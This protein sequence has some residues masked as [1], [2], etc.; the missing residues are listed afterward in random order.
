MVAA[1]LMRGESHNCLGNFSMAARDV[2]HALAILPPLLP[3]GLPHPDHV[4]ARYRLVQI[5]KELGELDKTLQVLRFCAAATRLLMHE[6][7][8]QPDDPEDF[9]DPTAQTWWWISFMSQSESSN[10]IMG[11]RQRALCSE[12]PKKT[13]CPRNWALGHMPRIDTSASI[14]K[15]RASKPNC[16]YAQS[17]EMSGSVTKNV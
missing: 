17:A 8:C 7:V 1:L 2:E 4:V 5:W 3:G 14:A 13:P 6:G 9:T 11:W 10:E 15:S 16:I 12:K